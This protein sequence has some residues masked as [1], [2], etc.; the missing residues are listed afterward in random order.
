MVSLCFPDLHTNEALLL[1]PPRLIF[2]GFK[3]VPYK[4]STYTKLKDTQIT[5]PRHDGR[6]RVMHCCYLYHWCTGYSE[7]YL[8]Q[9]RQI[10]VSIHWVLLA[11]NRHG[12]RDSSRD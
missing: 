6:L 12:S 9:P 10:L 3:L 1:G 11:G 4:D 2:L 5:P 8:N 7:L